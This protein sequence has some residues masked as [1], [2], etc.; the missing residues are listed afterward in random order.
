MSYPDKP[1]RVETALAVLVATGG[2][3]SYGLAGILHGLDSVEL[4]GPSVCLPPHRRSTL[5]GVRRRW[6]DEVVTV[7]GYRCSSARRTLLDLATALDADVWEQALESALRKRLVSIDDLATS[8]GVRMRKLLANR[9][10]GA[11]PT[12]SLLETLMV[13]LIRDAGLPSPERQV[14][15][16]DAYG[17]FVARVD[18]AWRDRGV[19]IEL[20]GMHHLHQPEHDARR[21]T[22]VVATTGWLPARFT[23]R[24]VTRHPKPTIKRLRELYA[25]AG[26]RDERLLG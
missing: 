8:C 10:P 19:F 25:V 21:E 13:Q 4:A 17:G 22:A 24:E 6:V 5:P 2:V 20:D 11:P 3:A 23:W 12:E 9:P 7:D 26:V 16:N 18:L 1:S 14:E 15:V